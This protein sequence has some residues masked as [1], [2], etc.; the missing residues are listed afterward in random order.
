MALLLTPPV[1]RGLRLGFAELAPTARLLSQALHGPFGA[2]P[3]ASARANHLAHHFIV[4]R[5]VL[6][7]CAQ[8]ATGPASHARPHF[9]DLLR[10]QHDDLAL[11]QLHLQRQGVKAA[12]HCD[13]DGGAMLRIAA[14]DTGVCAFEVRAT[15]APNPPR[16]GAAHAMTLRSIELRAQ[17]PERAATHWAQMLHAPL[18]RG[19]DGCPQLLVTPVPL[20]FLAATERTG[21]GVAAL[22]FAPADGGAFAQRLGPA[23]GPGIGWSVGG[24]RV[25]LDQADPPR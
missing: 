16:P 25:D 8:A 6:D 12:E 15:R 13:A 21:T 10:W 24:L 11:L 22:R 9:S 20:R 5:L 3:P 23:A 18:G 1:L 7:A 17:A 14:V 2:P 4:D 19:A